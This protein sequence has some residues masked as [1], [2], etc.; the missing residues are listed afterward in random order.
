ME[1]ERLKIKKE[2]FLKTTFKSI[3]TNQEKH[4]SY[5]ANILN[6]N[7]IEQLTNRL[8]LL[9]RASEHNFDADKF[10]ELCD[11]KGKTLVI[12]R[13]KKTQNLFG[14]YS[15]VAWFSNGSY[16]SAPG[17]FLFSLD[18]QTKHNIFRNEENAIRRYSVNGPMFGGSDLFLSISKKDGLSPLPTNEG[19]SDLG[20]SYSLPPNIS[21]YT[22]ESYSYL[23]G[24]YHFEV[25][26]YE[27]F[28]VD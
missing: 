24:S 9:Y 8:H 21:Y 23:A 1:I 6:F 10:H 16:S 25:E 17:S 18:K 3:H 7:S 14:G 4:L 12:V 13:S 11:G 22:N 15:T 27:V 5:L 26:E 2:K 20:N 28:L 19:F